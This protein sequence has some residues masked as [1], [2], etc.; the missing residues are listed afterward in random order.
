[1]ANPLSLSSYMN[2]LQTVIS[3]DGPNAGTDTLVASMTVGGATITSNTLAITWIAPAPTDTPTRTP[4][5][6]PTPTATET[7]TP[8]ATPT[9]TPTSTPTVTAVAPPSVAAVVATI[10]LGGG[11]GGVAVNPATHRVYV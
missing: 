6:T 4:T 3:Y 5:D 11:P 2:D 1:G 9:D 10:P 8:T 7:A